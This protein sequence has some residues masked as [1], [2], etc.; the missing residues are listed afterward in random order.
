MSTHKTASD[1]RPRGDAVRLAVVEAA[2]RLLRQE[3]PEFSMR[4]L[5]TEAGVSF[6]T[7]FNRF[8][9]KAAIMRALSEQRIDAMAARFR[10]TPPPGDAVARVLAATEIATAVM[11]EEPAVNRAVMGWLGAPGPGGVWTHS[12]AFWRLALADADGLR[13]PEQAMR[14]LP[15]LLA[16]GFR[17]VLSF[18]T[19]GDLADAEL[20][21]HARDVARALLAGYG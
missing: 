9:S 13:S 14:E 1:P 5:A 17:G 3:R 11:L 20:E 2:E 4:D 18:W 16:F 21:H 6:A 12:A 7:P 19:A 10:A 15:P 8:G